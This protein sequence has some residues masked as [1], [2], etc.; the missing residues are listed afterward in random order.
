MISPVT[1]WKI[2]RKKNC[3]RREN[4][5]SYEQ[6]FSGILNKRLR[7]G[8]VWGARRT[9]GFVTISLWINNKCRRL[10]R[11]KHFSARPR[12]CHKRLLLFLPQLRLR[13]KLHQTDV[14][15]THAPCSRRKLSNH[16]IAK[17]NYGTRH[18]ICVCLF[19]KLKN[20]R[21]LPSGCRL[22]PSLS[23]TWGRRFLFLA[24]S[25]WA[26]IVNFALLYVA[27]C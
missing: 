10:T 19:L 26:E 4:F 27:S 18:I 17:S 20:F 15:S 25:S 6:F 5:K 12:S 21:H 13:R 8:A 9:N 16:F 11:Q 2:V 22:L 3:F 24:H 1:I 14:A 7:H 23:A